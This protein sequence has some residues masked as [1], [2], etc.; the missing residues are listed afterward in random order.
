VKNRERITTADFETIAA[1]P[2][3]ADKH[4]EFISGEIFEVVSNNL[5]SNIAARFI[6]FLFVYLLQNDL[7]W[8]TTADGGYIVGGERY[9]PDVG[10]V[11]YE[12]AAK[13][14]PIDYNPVPPDL[15]VEVVSSERSDE[16]RTL[17]IKVT[18]Y[19]LARTIVWVVRPEF[20]HVEV[21][22]PGQPVPVYDGNGAVPGGT[23]LPSFTLS[24]RDLFK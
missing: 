8:V 9:I 20:Q 3:N 7:G 6:G 19:L 22:A 18:N 2:E 24:I 15:A 16:N 11:T 4:L 21:H 10:F 1:L 5:A 13:P 14:E 23:L 17:N 12:K